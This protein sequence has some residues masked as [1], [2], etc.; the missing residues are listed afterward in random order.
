MIKLGIIYNEIFS[1]EIELLYRHF[2]K[3]NFNVVVISS[4]NISINVTNKLICNIEKEKDEIYTNNISV[5]LNFDEKKYIIPNFTFYNLTSIPFTNKQNNI[6]LEFNNT[7]ILEFNNNEIINSDN[8]IKQLLINNSSINIIEY[9]NEAYI[10]KNNKVS[11]I[12]TKKKQINKLKYKYEINVNVYCSWTSSKEI[13]GAFKRFSQSSKGNIH[14]WSFKSRKLNITCDLPNPDFNYVM[15]AS[16]QAL[17]TN[18]ILFCM[19]PTNQ[20]H[21][22][23]YYN[24]SKQNNIT[25]YGTH[26]YHQN[27]V[28]W[29]LTKNII[30]LSTE[31]F[32]K[33]HNKVLSV[34]VSDYYRDPGHK[35]RI[36]FIRE[37]DNRAKE[38]KLPFELHI[39]GRCKSLNFHCFKKELKDGKDEGLI[40]Y[41]YH[42]NAENMS[43]DN[44]V[45]EKFNDSILAECLIFYWGCPNLETLYDKNSFV[46]LSLLKENYEKEIN[47]INELMNANEYDKRLSSIIQTKQDIIYNRS[48]FVRINNVITL[49][50][51]I[52]YLTIKLNEEDIISLKTSCF[53]TIAGL[54]FE[55]N[56]VQTKLNIIQ[57]I[58]TTTQDC[59][60]INK[61]MDY[62]DVYNKLSLVCLDTYDIVFLTG[63]SGDI[64]SD[65]VWIKLEVLEDIYMNILQ[66]YQQ[67]SNREMFEKTFHQ[68]L[69]MLIKIKK[70]NVK[71][72]SL[73]N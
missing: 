30:E 69:S 62:S 13:I 41:K 56:N 60:L 4:N 29:H 65:N 2:T 1:N 24:I 17:S 9:N 36:D 47:K 45:T 11:E 26:K 49:S 21:F 44:Y 7:S 23:N 33:E 68:T 27:M 12:I 14:S 22:E 57:H 72:L 6:V 25:F 46:R 40:P 73:L 48:M 53:K 32:K 38:G 52:V 19:E 70:Y 55:Q 18:T 5:F 42:F 64:F 37:L 20:P 16:N 54:Q 8:F 28:D 51:V 61:E 34:I 67:Q 71:Y 43:V 15:N 39:Y 31:T 58:L 3:L 50:D 10:F 66:I 59:I 35:L 63:Q